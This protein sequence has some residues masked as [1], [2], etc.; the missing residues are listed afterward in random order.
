[1]FRF[2]ARRSQSGLSACNI[3][4]TENAGEGGS[5]KQLVY[6]RC[7]KIDIETVLRTLSFIGP[8]MQANRNL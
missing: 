7:F 1:M 5:V 3:D 6:S 8:Y 4:P 2:A